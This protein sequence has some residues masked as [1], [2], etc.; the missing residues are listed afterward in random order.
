MSLGVKKRIKEGESE[1]Q[2]T[3]YFSSKQE[4]NIAKEKERQ[5]AELRV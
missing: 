2:P 3:R 4:K 1:K 5:I